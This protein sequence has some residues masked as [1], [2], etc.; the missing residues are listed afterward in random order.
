MTFCLKSKSFCIIFT[1]FFIFLLIIPSKAFDDDSFSQNSGDEFVFRM[2][3]ADATRNFQWSPFQTGDALKILI[4]NRN[5]TEIEGIQYDS[6]WSILYKKTTNS[7][8]WLPFSTEI[9][10]GT[11]NNT[12]IGRNDS[13]YF[14]PHNELAANLTLNAYMKNIKFEHINWTSGP[15][16][17]DGTLIAYNGSKNGD[18][19]K[20]RIE[21]TYLEAGVLYNWRFFIGNGSYWQQTEYFCLQEPK[22][23]Q[24]WI[25]FLIIAILFLYPL[26]LPILKRGEKRIYKNSKFN[27]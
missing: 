4:T 1:L 5:H 26:V 15:H 18:L 11:Y 13:F 23:T 6:L 10:I 3:E 24:E 27:E 12:Y 9:I 20:T 2:I 25:I 21:L 16:G 14:I 17:Y 8:E 19:N 22:T 7:S